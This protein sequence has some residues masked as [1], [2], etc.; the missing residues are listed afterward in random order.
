MP[1]LRTFGERAIERPFNDPLSDRV[2]RMTAHRNDQTKPD[3]TEV[4]EQLTLMRPYLD[5][6]AP[7]AQV[8]AAAGIALRTARRWVARVRDGGPCRA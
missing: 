6:D 8:A 5:G 1:G 2:S 3:R 4:A 7:R